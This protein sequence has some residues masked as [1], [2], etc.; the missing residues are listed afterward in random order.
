[1]HGIPTPR[2]DAKS[3]QLESG[4]LGDMSDAPLSTKWHKRFLELTDVI[5]GWSK[6]PSRG[7]GALIVTPNR[8]IV[9][10]GFNGL[11]RGFEDTPDRL[12]RPHKYDFVVH[13]ELNALIQCARNGVSPIGCT[14]YS[15]FSPCVNC[16]IS[17]VQAGIT[18]VVTYELEE[19]DARWVDSIEK[20]VEVF[21]ESGIS[22]LRMPRNLAGATG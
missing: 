3:V 5:A 12:Q 8:Q 16:A 14:I 19:S 18:S 9:A 17:L 21:A 22:Y 15:S 20:S 1:M 10:T 7:V 4:T 6:D 13:A 11:P 2:H